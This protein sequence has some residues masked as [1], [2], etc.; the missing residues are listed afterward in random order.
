VDG[1][2]LKAAGSSHWVLTQEQVEKKLAR[3]EEQIQGIEQQIEQASQ[4]EEE[5]SLGQLPEQLRDRK[6]LRARMEKA[7]ENR[8]GQA[9]KRHP[10]EG[11]ARLMKKVG[12]G[13][14]GQ[15]VVDEKAHIIVAND[16]SNEANDRHQ[17]M[18]M[19]DKV[20]ETYD[21]VAD[22]TVADGGYHTAEAI[23]QASEESYPVIV[24]KPEKNKSKYHASQF[25]YDEQQDVVICPENQLLTFERETKRKRQP[26]AVRIYRSRVCHQC[27]VRSSCTKDRRGRVIEV[28]PYHRAVEQQRQKREQPAS[29]QL[30]ARRL[31]LGERDFAEIKTRLAFERFRMQGLAAGRLEWSFVCAVYNLKE[32]LHRVWQPGLLARLDFDPS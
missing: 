16:L 26:Y 8:P 4:S 23:G 1:T 11:E 28:S 14:N 6:R 29:Q 17:L 24:G 5:T 21:R 30:Y 12:L 27:P 3:L 2:K 22:E 10:E 20:H 15:T 32:L 25:R 18:P 31:T 19:L 7:L 13:Y 9:G